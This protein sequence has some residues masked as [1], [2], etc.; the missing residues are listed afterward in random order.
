MLTRVTKRDRIYTLLLLFVA[1][2]MVIDFIFWPA[3]I[4][5]ITL[6][7]LVQ[8]VGIVV[9]CQLWQNADAVE[10]DVDRSSGSWIATLLLPPLGI[11]MHLFQ[12]RKW[13]I[14]LPVFLLFWGGYF[15]SIIVASFLMEAIM[16]PTTFSFD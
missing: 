15:M 7:D 8:M 3:D 6:N 11:G 1:F 4:T 16:N 13:Q 2:G 5:P 14:A 10:L 9:L 12:T